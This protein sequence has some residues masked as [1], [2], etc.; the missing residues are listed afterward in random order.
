[1]LDM[2]CYACVQITDHR[3][4]PCITTKLGELTQVPG[5]PC[6]QQGLLQSPV[7]FPP[8]LGIHHLHA[9]GCCRP[10]TWNVSPRLLSSSS[11]ILPSCSRLLQDNK[12]DKQSP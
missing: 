10:L 1:M 12:S 4:D 2:F 8:S 11:P 3:R 7:S 5:W 9:A 6:R